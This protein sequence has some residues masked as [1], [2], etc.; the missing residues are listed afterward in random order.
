MKYD[1]TLEKTFLIA[2]KV[3]SLLVRT[4]NE[5]SIY[6]TNYNRNGNYSSIN[7]KK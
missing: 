4:N 7:F 2:K 6:I 3:D 1:I 5:S